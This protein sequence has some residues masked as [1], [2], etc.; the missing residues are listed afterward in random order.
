MVRVAAED[1]RG[2]LA[3]A[4]WGQDFVAGAPAVIALAA[5]YERVT[6]KY[7]ARGERYAHMEAG[8]A[9]QNICLQAEALGAGT[10]AVGAFDDGAVQRALGM[11]RDERPLYLLPVGTPSR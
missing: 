9:A 11:G 7:R 10:V 5:V 6:G 4:A 3:R 1:A 8:H 2:D